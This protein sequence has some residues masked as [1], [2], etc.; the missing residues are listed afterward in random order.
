MSNTPHSDVPW[1]DRRPSFIP[2]AWRISAAVECSEPLTGV[3]LTHPILSELTFTRCR[4]S[5]SRA[6]LPQ[7]LPQ[8]P[9]QLMPQCYPVYQETTGLIGQ[10]CRKACR[11][12]AFETSYGAWIDR[13][14]G[15]IGQCR[16][17]REKQR[18]SER[19]KERQISLPSIRE[20]L[21]W[22]DP[23]WSPPPSYSLHQMHLQRRLVPHPDAAPDGLH[24]QLNVRL[25]SVAPRKPEQHPVHLENIDRL[26]QTML[27]DRSF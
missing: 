19:A 5:I 26:E 3:E 24:P 12:F 27:E 14:R 15:G 22:T 4:G 21:V 16:T 20:T 6:S 7:P 23:S 13:T 2:L 18:G 1:T 25:K 10:A 8:P 17:K 11:E 9:L